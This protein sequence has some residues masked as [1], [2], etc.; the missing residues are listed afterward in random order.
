MSR[1]LVQAEILRLFV[2]EPALQLRLERRGGKHRCPG[3]LHLLGINFLEL[4]R[5]PY[6]FRVDHSRH[7]RFRATQR[8]GL[9]VDLGFRFSEAVLDD[10]RSDVPSDLGLEVAREP[11][12]K[13]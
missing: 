4:V 8:V 1:N 9:F 10:L 13:C 2:Q 12:S 11:A 7:H 5:D 6:H 3:W